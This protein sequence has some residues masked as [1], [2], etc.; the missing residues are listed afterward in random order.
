MTTLSRRALIGA[1]SAGGALV[2]SGARAGIF[3]AAEPPVFGPAPGV[4]LLSR[5]ENP[6][7]PAPS[8]VAAMAESATKGCYYADGGLRRLTDIIAERFGLA[9]E[10]VAIGSGST[11]VLCGIALAWKDKG[12][13]LCNDLFWDTTVQ[14]G[15][16]QGTKVKRVP[17]GADLGVDLDTLAAAVGPDV[18][19]VHICNPN[20][21]T[22][23]VLDGDALRAFVRKVGPKV[24]VLVDEAY[25]ELTDRPEYNSVAGLVKE[26][27]NVIVCRTFS[28]IYG[29][30]GL[31]VG[32]ALGAPEA[33]AKINTYLM[34]FGGNS[35][36]LAAAIASYNDTAFMRYSKEKIVEAR[37][38]LL[39]AI[40]KA[41][42]SALPA[43]TNFLYVKVADAD[44][45]QKAMA[46][47]GILI[48]GAY[49]KWTGWSRVSTGRIEDVKRYAAALPEVLGA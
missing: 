43:E 40:K 19:L 1:A 7:G 5:N 17:L 2:A 3:P 24:T 44:A 32:Y 30:A 26:G 47:K 46:A 23:R 33:I 10:N 11:E 48:R 37:G 39:D 41:G 20:N 4:A 21:P 35:A 15:E 49:G 14:Y 13:I 29:M 22:G 27:H 31:R 45:V 42:T 16:R 18:G 9:K 28:K 36:G 8:A 25:N 34:S 12:A 38:I 6:Y